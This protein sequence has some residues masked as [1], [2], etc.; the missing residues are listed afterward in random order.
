MK[1]LSYRNHPLSFS[2]IP[3]QDVPV[4]MIGGQGVLG[5]SC[6]ISAA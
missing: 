5:I 2:C 4:S 3:G 1:F 6:A